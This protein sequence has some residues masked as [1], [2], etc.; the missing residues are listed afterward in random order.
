MDPWIRTYIKGVTYE[1]PN[2]SSRQNI[3]RG[4]QKGD[5]LT[6][7]RELDNPYDSN[8]VKVCL[9]SK[10]KSGFLS[11]IL[12]G[13]AVAKQLGYLSKYLASRIA[14]LMDKGVPVYAEIRDFRNSESTEIY[15]SGANT[16]TYLDCLIEITAHNIQWDEER[17][18]IPI[19]S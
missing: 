1:N 13:K 19:R 18:P 10:E 16:R 12:G 9:S 14:P 15:L 6:L 8:A 3:L 7:V 4:C 17:N 5:I 11:R 2:G